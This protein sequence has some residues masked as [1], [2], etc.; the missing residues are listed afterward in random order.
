MTLLSNFVK[1]VY[2]LPEDIPSSSA[3]METAVPTHG[4]TLAGV[5]EFHNQSSST[6]EPTE[7]STTTTC[8]STSNTVQCE[9]W[10][11]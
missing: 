3:S 11:P 6:L 4:N 8:T 9:C 1:R 5:D 7:C 2:R 10:H